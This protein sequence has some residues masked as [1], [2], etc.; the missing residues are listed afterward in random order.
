M[1]PHPPL[2]SSPADAEARRLA[3][4]YAGREAAVH[5]SPSDPAQRWTLADRERRTLALLSRESLGSLAN[6]RILEVGCGTGTWLRDLVRWGASPLNVFGVEILPARAA[7]A[8]RSVAP[9]VTVLDG[10]IAALEFPDASFD[11]VI[12]STVFSSILDPERRRRTA[13][14][15]RRVLR[16]DG[17]IL[18]YDLAMDN[19]RNP[20]V[21]GVSRAGISSLF[22]GCRVLAERITLAPP[23]ARALAP[24]APWACTLLNAFPFLRTHLLSAIRPA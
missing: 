21:R 18:W 24:H 11:L 8:R 13:A 23:I 5:D 4:A 19:P 9:G 1:P 16:P 12:Q 15:M 6:T 22:P 20:N 7:E 2:P 3:A 10:D 17:L 14:E